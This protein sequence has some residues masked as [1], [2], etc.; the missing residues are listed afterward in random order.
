MTVLAVVLGL[1]LLFAL[2]RLKWRRPRCNVIIG[3]GS[4]NNIVQKNNDSD[5]EDLD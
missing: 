4:G 2:T 1:L 3:C 5:E